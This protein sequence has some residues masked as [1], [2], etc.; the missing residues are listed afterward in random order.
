MSIRNT[1]VVLFNK[2][3]G[4]SLRKNQAANHKRD[5]VKYGEPIL[6]VTAYV[7]IDT[8]RYFA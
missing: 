2:L 5:H 6:G 7:N 1:I 8:D 4:L 3:N